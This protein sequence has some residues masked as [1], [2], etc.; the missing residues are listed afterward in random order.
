M[1][2]RHGLMASLRTA[3]L[4]ALTTV[5]MTGGAAVASSVWYAGDGPDGRPTMLELHIDE[6]GQAR[7]RIVQGPALAGETPGLDVAFEGTAARGTTGVRIDGIGRGFGLPDDGVAVV[8]AADQR[9]SRGGGNELDPSGAALVSFVPD[10][11]PAWRASLTAVAIGVRSIT[12]LDDGSLEVS[13]FGP[14]FHVQPWSE[15]DVAPDPTDL[16]ESVL[17]GLEQRADGPDG[18]ATLLWWDERVVD[19]TALTPT[20]LSV[21]LDF[22]AYTG[23]AHPNT[24]Y[25]FATWAWDDDAD[26]WRSADA[27]SA[28]RSLGYRCDPGALRSAITDDLRSQ[29]AA[30]VVEGSVDATTPWLLDPFTVTT[31]GLQFDY[32]PYD[33][34]PYAQGPFRVLLPFDTLPAR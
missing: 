16:A 33:V 30:W 11:G 32:A 34:G 31:R 20:M 14:F 23:G 28:L 18:A 1:H 26:E 15:L 21:R 13:A 10:D 29:E 27:C 5:L 17:S 6:D 24:W 3:A 22:Y 25:A 7:G 4:A 2:A 19:V 9:V 12:S 8:I